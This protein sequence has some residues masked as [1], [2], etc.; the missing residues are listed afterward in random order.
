MSNYRLITNSEYISLL[1]SHKLAKEDFN[2]EI[3]LLKEKHEKEIYSL[4]DEINELREKIKTPTIDPMKIQISLGRV[5]KDMGGKCTFREDLDIYPQNIDLS[6]DVFK[7]IFRLSNLVTDKL[8][9]ATSNDSFY[10]GIKIGK[11]KA[12]EEVAKM[13]FFKRFKF[14]RKYK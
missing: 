9:R 8:R 5:T 6:N 2:K 10:S 12:Y 1:D 13:G 14:L 4:N 3:S 11:E 7:Q